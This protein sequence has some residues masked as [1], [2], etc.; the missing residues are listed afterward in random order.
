[1]LVAKRVRAHWHILERRVTRFRLSWLEL[2]KF[3]KKNKF[4]LTRSMKKWVTV[5]Q[6]CAGN[7]KDDLLVNE[8]Y[9]RCWMFGS[10]SP[11]QYYV[12]FTACCRSLRRWTS[13]STSSSSSPSLQHQQP[14]NCRLLVTQQPYKREHASCTAAERFMAVYGT[15][16]SL[17]QYWTI[18]NV[19]SWWQHHKFGGLR[20]TSCSVANAWHFNVAFCT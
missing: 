11:P 19:T 18:N 15:T 8:V 4:R 12:T 20:A 5:D 6:Y 14:C 2:G 10:L 16:I 13:P 7:N 1:M 17:R 3:W 9:R